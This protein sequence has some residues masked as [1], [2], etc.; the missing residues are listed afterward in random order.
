MKTFL[1][2]I[3]LTLFTTVASAFDH[4]HAAFDTLLKKHV[5]KGLVDY[6]GVGQDRA[7]LDTYVES[8]KAVS[9]NDFKSWEK[10]Q[11]LAFLINLYN[12]VTLQVILDH[13]P[14][15]SI[16]DINGGSGPWKDKLVPLLGKTISLDALENDVIRPD[17]NEPRIHFALVCA[18]MGCPP[19]RKGAFTADGLDAQL[20]EQTKAFLSQS[21]KNRN[22]GGTLH[23]SPLF[24]WYGKD[25]PGGPSK[26]VEP[27]LGESNRIK[28]TE[29]DW[30]LNQS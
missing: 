29:Y 28:F 16:K 1:P 4:S 18:A 15:K 17:F 25:F 22:D 21:K 19:L 26:W 13:H 10:D 30:S 2:L 7:D 8:L 11:R 24:D 5:S 9:K 14:L 23:L 6:P 3:A 27:W 12:A 20:S